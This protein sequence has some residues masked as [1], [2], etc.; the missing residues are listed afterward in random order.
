MIPLGRLLHHPK[1]NIR[2]QAAWAIGN[3]IGDREGYRD[4][5]LEAGLLPSILNIWKG[6]HRDIDAQK[7]SFRIS[8][9]IVDNMCRYKPDWQMMK[10]A[11]DVIPEVLMNEDDPNILKECCWAVARILHQSGRDAAI[12]QM[13]SPQICSRLIEILRWGKP[14]TTHPVLRALINLSSSRNTT[15][16]KVIIVN[17]YLVNAGLITQLEEYLVKDNECRQSFAVFAIQIIGNLGIHEEYASMIADRYALCQWLLRSMFRTK[18]AEITSE[19]CIL[20]RNMLFHK[21]SRI[22]GYCLFNQRI[23][24]NRSPTIVDQIFGKI[25]SRE[26]DSIDLFRSDQS[27]FED[28]TAI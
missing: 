28:I 16:L 10:P 9:W 20:I 18:D 15:H 26:Q 12:D 11:F 4:L 7:E 23:S 14:L 1:G 3:I 8:F 17:K 5:V 2:T 22:A 27:P 24:T 13:I 25:Y 21:N 19:I 6:E